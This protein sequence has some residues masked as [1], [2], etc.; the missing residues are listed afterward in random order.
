[1]RLRILI[2]TLFLAFAYSGAPTTH[3]Q[4]PTS[5]SPIVVT[6]QSLDMRFP[7]SMRFTIQAR[8]TS[9]IQL[10]R[11]TVW[12]RGVAI[13]SRF[14]PPLNPAPEVS[15]SFDWNFVGFNDGGYLPP[16]THGEYTWHIEDAHGNALDTPRTAFVVQDNTQTWQTLS[17]GEVSLHWHA[18]DRNFGNAVYQRALEA[19]A[20]LSDRLKIENVAPLEIFIYADR[21]DFFAALPAFSAEWTGG[22][23]FP[24][25]GVIMINFEPDDLDF[26][27]RATSHELSHAIL[28]AKVRGLIGE[29]SLPQW[30]DEGLAV[31]NETGDHAPDPQFEQGF[32]TAV[33]HNT[34]IPLRKLEGRFPADSFQAQLAYGESYY[35][36]KFMIDTYGQDK[37]AELLDV[38]ENGSLPDPALIKVYGMNQD[39]LENAWRVKLG[40]PTRE[41]SSSVMPTLA[42]RPT[43]ELSLPETPASPTPLAPPTPQPTQ[44]SAVE[45]P[46]D[47]APSLPASQSGAPES[48]L[49]GGALALGGMVA[50]GLA[51][52]RRGA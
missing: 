31:Y 10:L 22:R 26:G 16:G 49:C 44:I 50:L 9:S 14:V 12:E 39:E 24:E 42:P 40:A 41:V 46:S 43:Y 52:R 6:A 18:G 1:M 3:A 34:L 17:N 15:A 20:F 29:L 13:G 51:R 48:T 21:D 19:R 11:L 33:R 47:S 2:A 23:M 32:Q 5:D 45:T 27:L 25:Y 30:L 4:N 28:H 7:R 38:F 36:V 35:V 37:F 8:S